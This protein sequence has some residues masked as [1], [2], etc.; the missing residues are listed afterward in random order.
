MEYK[1]IFLVGLYKTGHCEIRAFAIRYCFDVRTG[2]IF[3]DQHGLRERI[4][5]A[6]E[7]RPDNRLNQITCCIKSRSLKWTKIKTTQGPNE[8]DSTFIDFQIP[9]RSFEMV[10]ASKKKTFAIVVRV[11]SQF[12]SLIL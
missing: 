5:Q 1:T 10:G 2:R 8:L 3:G 7:I 6:I 11:V 4:E 12:Q 9:Y